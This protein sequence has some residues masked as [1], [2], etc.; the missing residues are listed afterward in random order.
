MV[1]YQ[2]FVSLWFDEIAA[3]RSNDATNEMK[4]VSEVWNEN[5]DELNTAT[6]AEARKALQ[7]LSR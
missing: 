7:R 6:T 3:R 1:S 4:A 5:R 2:A